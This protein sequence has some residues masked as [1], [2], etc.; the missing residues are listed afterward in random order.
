MYWAILD[1]TGRYW[2]VLGGTTLHWVGLMSLLMIHEAYMPVYMGFR[3]SLRTRA[4]PPEVVQEALADLKSL[5]WGEKSLMLRRQV[6]SQQF[7]ETFMG[8][9]NFSQTHFICVMTDKKWAKKE[10]VNRKNQTSGLIFFRFICFRQKCTFAFFYL[11][12]WEL[13]EVP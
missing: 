12:G 10:I 1:C 5:L 7:S 8:E 9:N 3:F 4:G 6:V 2:T 11:F 13:I